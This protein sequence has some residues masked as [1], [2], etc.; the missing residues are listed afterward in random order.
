MGSGWKSTF[1]GGRAGFDPG[2]R[3]ALAKD[4]SAAQISDQVIYLNTSVDD[5]GEP[6]TAAHKY[7]ASVRRREA[8]AGDRLL[9]HG[10]ALLRRA[11]RRK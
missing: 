4:E 8:P 10:D 9:K 6:L 3:G 5:K 2:I 1:A 7:F 11:L